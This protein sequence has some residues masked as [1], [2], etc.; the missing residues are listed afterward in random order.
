M[1]PYRNYIVFFILVLIGYVVF[2]ATQPKEVHWFVTFKTT[3]VSPFG[4]FIL[5]ERAT[6]LFDD[7]TVS[8]ATISQFEEDKNLFILAERLE[9]QHADLKKLNELLEEGRNVMIAAGGFSPLM[10]DSLGFSTDYKFSFYGVS[11]LE[12]EETK[13]KVGEQ[14]FDYPIEM[15]TNYFEVNKE[16]NWKVL[17][18]TENG[19]IAIQRS[20]GNG[21]LILVTNPLIFTNFGLLYNE[22]YGAAEALLNEMPESALHYTMFYQ[23][24]RPEA[25]TPLRYFLSQPALKWSIYLAMFAIVFYLGIDAWRKQRSIPIL[26]PPSNTSIEYA[27][28][29]GGLFHREGNHYK[30]ALKLIN[31][32]YSDIRERFYLEPEHSEKFYHQLSSKSGMDKGHVT[33]IFKLI[34][35]IRKTPALS[36]E[37]LVEL[38]KKIDEF[39]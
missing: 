35:Q 23:F 13:L 39:Q 27:Q 33:E 38:S 4:A 18:T 8:Y 31:H 25:S 14:F 5:H 37:L 17:A 36:E 12:S 22:N 19:P 9:L 15:V 6:D 24:G 16:A 26:L 28:T 29:L 34:E 11:L 20:I 2:V 21:K 30:T 10:Q 7:W 1:R 3:D 32:F